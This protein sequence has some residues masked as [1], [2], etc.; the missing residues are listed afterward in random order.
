MHTYDPY[1]PSWPPRHLEPVTPNPPNRI[2]VPNP[3]GPQGPFI[4]PV[5]RPPVWMLSTY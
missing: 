2:P 4:Q 1:K 3:M 5:W